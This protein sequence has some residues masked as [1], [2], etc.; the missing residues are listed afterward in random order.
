[1][2]QP[3]SEQQSAIFDVWA[4]M[5]DDD[6]RDTLE[7]LLVETDQEMPLPG[8]ADSIRARAEVWV[9]T[10]LHKTRSIFFAALWHSF[11]ADDQAQAITWMEK[12]RK[13]QPEA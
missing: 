4:E 9:A 13:A 6:R 11:N 10:T 5:R 3:V 8:A 7:I 2:T 12:N 1:M